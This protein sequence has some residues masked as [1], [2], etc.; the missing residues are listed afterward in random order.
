MF[1]LGYTYRSSARMRQKVSGFTL[2]E[3]MVTIIILAIVVSFAVPSF[4][5][6]VLESRI[7]SQIN[8]FSGVIALARSEATKLQGGVVSV[9]SSTDGAACNGGASWDQGWILFRDVDADGVI[10]NGVD[11]L[12]KV[13]SVLGGGNTARVSGLSSNDGTLIQ[14]SSRGFPLPATVGS[15]AA[16]TLS[17]C[18]SRGA[19]DARAI[20]VGVSGQVR[21]ARDENGDG[22]VDDHNGA[23]VT[24]P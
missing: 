11:Q 21:L 10:D 5:Q 2:L 16:G 8:E 19:G 13:G 17:V 9:C 4:R 18:D 3:L 22:I 12:I 7:G 24:C 20:V 15:S 14:F 23:S 1:N 6:T